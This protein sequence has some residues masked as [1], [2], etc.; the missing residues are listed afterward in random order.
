MIDLSNIKDFTTNY[1][2]SEWSLLDAID[3]EKLPDIHKK[4]FFFLDEK[5]DK[6]I[7]EFLGNARILTGNKWEPFVKGNFKTVETFDDCR[8]VEGNLQELKKWLFNRGIPFKN[9]VYILPDGGWQ[10]I[11]TTWKMTIKYAADLFFSSDV[12]VFDNSLNWCLFYYS[13]NKFFFGKDNVYN[14]ADPFN[15]HFSIR[16]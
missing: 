11:L 6:Y 14:P 7:F 16:E 1:P 13:H 5:A 15:F 10:P 9:E 8:H 2:T 4:Q 12:V 3:F